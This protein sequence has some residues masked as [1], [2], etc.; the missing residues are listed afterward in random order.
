M[1]ATARVIEYLDRRGVAAALIGGFALGAHGIARATLDVD[2][3][4]ADAVVLDPPFW[5]EDPDLGVP[6]IRR[7]D[8]S[9]PLLGLVRFSLA[10]EPVDVIVGRGAWIGHVLERRL[11]ITVGGHP[12]PVVDRVDLV[13]LKLFAGGPQDLLDVR[14]LLEAGS[15]PLRRQVEERLAQAPA[16]V[17]DAWERLLASGA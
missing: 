2:V 11:S 3:L 5:A 4:V 1:N 9:D 10:D 6:E 14:L 8:S 12:L 17:R 7:G 15:T 13:L 16:S